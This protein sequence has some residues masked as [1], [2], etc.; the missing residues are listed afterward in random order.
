MKRHISYLKYVLRHKYYVFIACLRCN[1]PLYQGLVHDWHKFLPSEW[2]A[3]AE[4]F[5]N[6]DGSKAKY[7][8]NYSFIVAWNLHQKRGKHHWQHWLL[9][10]DR[11]NTIPVD[12]PTN[13]ILEMIA[14]W[15]GAG[16]AVTGNWDAV[17][18]YEK[19]KTNMNMSPITRRLTERFLYEFKDKFI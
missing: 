3:Y 11:G 5:Y 12:M 9:T 7:E 18:W 4:T 1:V 6:K 16:K 15:W 8:E 2:F 19:N 14:D 17:N 10:W 13:Y